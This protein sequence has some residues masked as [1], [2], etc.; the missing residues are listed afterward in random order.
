MF[1]LGSDKS[2]LCLV[3]WGLLAWLASGPLA[4]C[5]KQDDGAAPAAATSPAPRRAPVGQWNLP[6]KP[7]YLAAHYLPWFSAD[8]PDAASEPW[9][10]WKWSGPGGGPSHDPRT[11]RPDGRR[12]IAAVDYP[13]IGAYDSSSAAVVRYHLGTMSA[14]G[15][16]AVIVLWY[17]PGS[18]SDRRLPT[19]LDEADRLGLRV[20]LCY[21]EKVNFPPYRQP[22]TRDAVVETAVADLN[23]ALSR[24]AGHPAY[25]KRNGKPFVCQFNGYGATRVGPKYLTPLECGEILGRL[26]VPV[27][28]GR[29]GLDE[30]YHPPVPSAYDWWPP[31]GGAFDAFARRAAALRDAG[32]L[33]FFATMLCPGFDDTG[34]W[35]WGDGPRRSDARGI[36][37]L[38]RTFDHALDGGPE[39]VQVVTWNDFNEGTEAEPTRERGFELLDAIE[40]WWGERTGRPVDLADNRRP[41]LDYVRACSAAQRQELP[42]PPFDAYLKPS[43]RAA[44][45]MPTMP[46][47]PPTAPA[48]GGKVP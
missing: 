12:D 2:R 3:T 26:T 41:F 48:A 35:G 1:G 9:D 46:T 21:E 10:H 27:E 20:A 22:E 33:D 32:R 7:P 39:L 5:S 11:R 17:G 29:S 14:A 38:R 42:A 8:S 16:Q 13:L 15:V 47:M 37:T 25:L 31:A 43:T 44:T 34:V 18:D 28:Y 36:A 40:T 23:D 24:Y 30:T 19:L 45:T 4:G 6:G